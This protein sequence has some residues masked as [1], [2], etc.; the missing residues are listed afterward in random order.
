[1][2]LFVINV[3]RSFDLSTF[4]LFQCLRI[5]LAAVIMPTMMRENLLPE[6]FGD[7]V[8]SPNKHSLGDSGVQ[9]YV[10]NIRS[11]SKTRDSMALELEQDNEML[12]TK[13]DDI[14]LQQEA[15]KSEIAEM[16]LQEGLAEVI[17]SSLSE[18]VAYLL[19]ERASLLE[20]RQEAVDTNA[21]QKCAQ[22]TSPQSSEEN[23]DKVESLR[24]Q[25]PWKRLLG[26]RKAAQTRQIF[27]PVVNEGSGSGENALK[28]RE[29]WL[30][31]RDLDEAS[32]RLDMAHREIRRLTDELE[33]ARLTQRAYEPELQEA[34]LEVEQLRQEV[35][36][37]KRCDVAE[38]RRAKEMN[39]ALDA[40]VRQLRD[41]VHRMQTERFQLLELID[42]KIEDLDSEDDEDVQ[43]FFQKLTKSRVASTG[44]LS[45]SK[46]RK[47]KDVHKRCCTELEDQ[48]QAVLKLQ[49]ELEEERML[50]KKTVEECNDH[51]KR[52]VA[53]EQLNVELRALCEQKE[54]EH[55]T[56]VQQLQEKLASLN[57]ELGQLKSALHKQCEQ[58]RQQHMALQAQADRAKVLSQSKEPLL[59][60]AQSQCRQLDEELQRVQGLLE[61]TKKELLTQTET[62]G[63]LQRN[64]GVLE[65][66]KL[67]V[68]T[69]LQ[70][71]QAKVTQ[72]QDK[73]ASQAAE[74]KTLQ[75][76]LQMQQAQWE[77]D[78]S[79]LQQE[80]E[81]LSSTRVQ[82]GSM[83]KEIEGLQQQ[84]KSATQQLRVVEEDRNAQNSTLEQKVRDMLEE[85]DTL[86]IQAE[87]AQKQ[88]EHLAEREREL[89]QQVQSLLTTNT[90]LTIAKAEM[91][92]VQDQQRKEQN[93]FRQVIVKLEDKLKCSQQETE[94]LQIQLQHAHF[95]LHSQISK[96]QDK[97]GRHKEK[98]CEAKEVYLRETAWRDEKI[99]EQERELSVL[100]KRT[101]KESE[102]V[103]K[104]TAENEVLLLSKKQLLCQLN[105]EEERRRHAVATVTAL[106]QRVDFL[107]KDSVRQRDLNMIKSKQIANLEGLLQDKQCLISTEDLK[108]LSSFENRIIEGSEQA[109]CSERGFETFDLL[110]IIQKTKSSPTE[111]PAALTR[112]RASEMDYLN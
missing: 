77:Q 106:Q 92:R 81:K 21:L 18:Q 16:L 76:K 79:L 27:T 87:N 74:L 19:A 47:E 104:V 58:A 52:R 83:E 35:E 84:L 9:Q 43:A 32:S 101:E 15:Q 42:F 111:E 22:N 41:S 80:Q 6:T 66:E 73:E 102:M 39:E 51:S 97:K 71:A 57:A 103:K 30:L 11:L 108:K 40:E 100:A 90:Q 91:S 86:K 5:I 34:Q 45:K 99:R 14:T 70:E 94:N 44:S 59:Q 112:S 17:P 62:S 7:S 89:Q 107:E 98:L 75:L 12:R 54:E 25:S 3:I 29:R 88:R 13:L 23:P 82:F 48:K 95:N 110:A 10:E 63:H 37:L 55:K 33:S 49:T 38:L 72:L 8:V 2:L 60:Q 96:Y 64:I 105:E 28:E 36:K 93:E 61:N 24:G 78:K 65:Q 20:K 109:N 46:K 53:A 56:R 1:M 26:I 69:E 68:V 31:E 85:F 4:I 50:Q 67:R